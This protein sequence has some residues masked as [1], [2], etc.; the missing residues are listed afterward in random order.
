MAGT[1]CFHQAS[2]IINGH[3]LPIVGRVSSEEEITALP[4]TSTA[5][6]IE[7]DIATVWSDVDVVAYVVDT[8]DVVRS[9][10]IRIP[11]LFVERIAMSTGQKIRVVA[12]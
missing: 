5:S 12:S 1:I 2:T 8:D 11:A 10:G 4:V 3:F 9:E 6:S 7:L